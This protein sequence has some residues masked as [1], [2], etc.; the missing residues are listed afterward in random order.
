MYKV[1]LVDDDVPVLE[2][3]QMALP[4]KELGYELLG[5]FDDPLQAL[6][7]V[8]RETPDL[9][10]TDIGMPD[11]NGIELI[12]AIK[13]K[14]QPVK[15]VILSCHDEFHYA[16]QAVRLGVTDYMLKET[17]DASAIQEVLV[18]LKRQ[19]D[20]EYRTS[21]HSR[22]LE[23]RIT[24]NKSLIKRQFFR[25]AMH[26][27]LSQDKVWL[28]GAREYGL[29]LAHHAYIPA[30]C[31]P[32]KLLD[33]LHRYNTKELLV[34]AMENITEE[35]LHQRPGAVSFAYGETDLLV[36]LPAAPGQR[37]DAS[38]Q[39]KDMFYQ[40]QEAIREY[41]KIPVSFL[42]GAVS[43][44]PAELKEQLLKLALAKEQRF[45]MPESAVMQAAHLAE[46]FGEGD[47]LLSHYIEAGEQF[48]HIVFEER[49]D[50]IEAVTRE[51]LD[52]I[53]YHRFRPVD[54][55]EWFLKIVLDIR[56]RLK[57]LE[58][59]PSSF[60]SELLHHDLMD[61][62]TLSELEAWVIHYLQQAVQWAGSVK[63]QSKHREI[64]ECQ[65]FVRSNLQRKISLE[66][67]AQHLHLHP[68]YLS[69]LF[70]RETGET[71]VEYVTR[72][73]M[74]KAKELLEMTDA[75]VEDI[76]EQLGYENKNYF[77]KLFKSFYG[78]TPSAF[79]R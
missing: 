50:R 26:A 18:R 1:M 64:V 74:E 60:S 72:A 4:W 2:F 68:N 54:V 49:T 45:Y 23:V 67:A 32:T 70:K 76:A 66:E 3:L 38:P 46:S 16:Q 25:N 51:W 77:G 69:R 17:M 41:A 47:I 10:L 30:L 59:F 42:L 15:A 5:A 43:Q 71:F 73:K 24:L 75:T 22:E 58:Q 35:L 48:R 31:Y 19:L 37:L 40:I 62:A 9:V 63:S 28:E 78:S 33:S 79:R 55:K 14:H 27:P 56:M 65:Q 44:K 29:D 36:L 34:Y 53:K 6:A 13:E 11:M 52:F 61:M 57:T 8:E 12:E 20:E 21:S 7:S 39:R